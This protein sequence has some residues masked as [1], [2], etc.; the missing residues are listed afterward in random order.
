[1][2][3]NNIIKSSIDNNTV[4]MFLTMFLLYDIA[5]KNNN[6]YKEDEDSQIVKH[7]IKLYTEQVKPD[8]VSIIYNFKKKYILH[9]SIVEQ[10]TPTGENKTN[11]KDIKRK[12]RDGLS[13]VYDY[14]QNFDIEKDYFNIFVQSLEIHKRLYTYFDEE[15]I[16]NK[17]KEYQEAIKLKEE[18]QKEKNLEKYKLSKEKL[19]NLQ[20]SYEKFGGNLRNSNVYLKDTDVKVPN[21]EIAKAYINSYLNPEKIKEYEEVLSNADIFSYIDYCVKICAE[22]IKYQPF[23]DGNKRTFRSLLN[24]MFKKRNLPP[25]YINPKERKAYKE[26]LVEG[27]KT[28]D[29]KALCSFYYYKI[30]DSIN[31]LDILPYFKHRKIND[32]KMKKKI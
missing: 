25:V 13:L 12:E 17:E 29:Y 24:L 5:K 14:I 16:K 26:A 27:M 2:G 32:I 28:D 4:E 9:E 23:Q 7:I 3:D 19:K 8:Y 15:N 31:E 1:M 20:T 18:A 30:C 22:L 21:P 10:N 11:I 6:L